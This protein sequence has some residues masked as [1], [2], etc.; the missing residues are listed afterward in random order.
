MYQVALSFLTVTHPQK[1]R[2]DCLD[3]HLKLIIC[4]AKSYIKDTKGFFEKKSKNF[5]SVPQSASLVIA[6]IVELHSS[7]P[8]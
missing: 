4:S 7:I 1:K 2:Q 6:D 8:H 3:Y 5:I